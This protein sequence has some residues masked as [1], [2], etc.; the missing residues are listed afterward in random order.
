MTPGRVS[1]RQGEGVMNQRAGTPNFVRRVLIQKE[2][3]LASSRAPPVP[4]LP[5][6]E[7]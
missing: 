3:L 5:E 1:D 6:L 2:C 7:T 4:L